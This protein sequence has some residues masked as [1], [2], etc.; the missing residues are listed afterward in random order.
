MAGVTDPPFRRMCRER[1]AALVFTEMVSADGLVRG[2]RRTREYL[3]I[4]PEERPVGV[5]LFGS[6]PSVMAEAAA[7]VARICGPDLIDLNG[8]CPVRK[9]VKKKAGA[10]LLLALDLL[11]ETVDAM[12]RAS[13]VPVTV[14]IRKGW[15]EAD[16]LGLEV[17]RVAQDAGASAVILHARSKAAGFSGPADWDAIRRLKESLRIPVV[18]NGGVTEPADALFMLERTGCDAVMIGRAAMGNPWI[19][20]RALSVIDRGVEPPPPTARERLDA[21]LWHA[22][23]L[24]KLRGETRAVKQMRKQAAWYT[25]GLPGSSAFRRRVN[26]CTSLR[27]LREAASRMRHE[28]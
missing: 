5:Q 6:E 4:L 3:E 15:T 23:E 2:N 14:K 1:G 16:E 22:A 25:K 17:A 24:A 12:V 26:E 10:A 28:A 27:E 11:G 19:F 13:P 20:S 18:G 21:F 8:G 9:V 7:L